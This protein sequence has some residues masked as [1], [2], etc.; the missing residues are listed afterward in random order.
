MP[1][2]RKFPYRSEFPDSDAPS[3]NH[4]TPRVRPLVGR[5]KVRS[6]WR[7]TNEHGQAGE[8]VHPDTSVAIIT[9]RNSGYR[10]TLRREESTVE[11]QTPAMLEDAAGHERI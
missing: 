10:W 2:Y 8:Y 7:E 4:Q 9:N 6:V 1:E 11:F 3:R 5:S